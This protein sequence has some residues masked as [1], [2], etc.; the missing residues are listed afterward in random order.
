MRAPAA[1]FRPRKAPSQRRSTQTVEAI[2]GAAARILVSRGWA[3]LTTNHVAQR[4]GVSIGTLYEYFPGK[5]ALVAA[6]LDRH[7]SRAEALLGERAAALASLERPPRVP[8][9]AEAIVAVMLE[10]H[11]D[12]PRLHRALAEEVPHP[13]A[14]RARLR[15]L[16]EAQ[17]DALAA[18]LGRMPDVRAPDPRLAAR[19]V[20]DVLEAAVH[21]WACDP[22]GTPVSRA[23]L[24][25]ELVRLVSA[26][27]ER[28]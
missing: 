21:R 24:E 12:A 14:T 5:E 11:E 19:I 4:A 7:L 1:R 18:V 27:L 28:G 23:D 22:S 15:E 8:E 13:P 17:V 26:Y 6:L 10:L 3:G 16:E 2:L 9:L 20:A 25:R